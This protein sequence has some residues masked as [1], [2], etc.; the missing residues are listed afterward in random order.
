MN[1]LKLPMMVALL[2]SAAGINAEINFRGFGSVVGGQAVSVDEGQR[3]L[4]YTD[5]MSFKQDS[6]M[7]LQ[8]DADLDDGLSATMQMISR[9]KDDFE[10]N[11]EWAYLTYELTDELQ[12][13]AGRIRAPFYRYSDFLDVRYAY[14]WIT[15]P[16]RVYAFDFP[17][18][19]GLSVLYNKS[20]GPI[21]NSLQVI[22]GTLD[23]V[24]GSTPILF[25][26]FIGASW[27]GSWEWLTGRASYLQATLSIEDSGAEGVA[28]GYEDLGK[29]MLG[30]AQGFGGFAAFAPTD[31][32]AADAAYYN[33]KYT[34]VGNQLLS[35]V[36]EARIKD[37]HGAYMALGFSVDKGSFIADAEW[38]HY[39]VDEALVPNTSAYYLTLGWRFGP[40]VV[41]GTYSREEQDART[42]ATN[43]IHDLSLVAGVIEEDD[44]LSAAL[45]AIP[46]L[47]GL[48]ATAVYLVRNTEATR[49]GI[50][51]GAVDRVNTHVGV[52]WDFH[53]SAAL[54]VSYEVTDNRV[55]DTQG[56][57]LRTAIDFVF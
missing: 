30:V 38:I 53:P 3:V 48:D 23:G 2:T 56:G 15:A 43:P 51:A 14:N 21:D 9:G 40:T 10:L 34:L 1:K 54:K 37:D 55:S 13:S 6:L 35:T 7:A 39:A 4:G 27:V 49:A 36:D 8:M 17:G 28:N 29:G 12:V 25:E 57:V 42:R 16:A 44:E 26:D 5:S 22:A 33:E 52:R 46:D 31:T 24:T 20:L 18:F 50:N 32:M 47:A 11:V 45:R 19:D 41:Y